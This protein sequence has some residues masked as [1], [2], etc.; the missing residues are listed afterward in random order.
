MIQSDSHRSQ[1]QN[2]QA[3]NEKLRAILNDIEN[4]CKPAGEASG[5][6]VK[7][8]EGFKEAFKM[9]NRMEMVKR[10]DKKTWRCLK[11]RNNWKS[12]SDDI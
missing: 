7:R 12:N 11:N 2:K 3:C 1:L 9:E 5:E 10:K 4:D 6:Q 8:V